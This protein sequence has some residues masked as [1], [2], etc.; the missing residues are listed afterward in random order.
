MGLG[1]ESYSE[2]LL[3]DSRGDGGKGGKG[4]KGAERAERAERGE[5]ERMS[6]QIFGEDGDLR[7]L[8]EDVE[9]LR[10]RVED[11]KN[12]KGENFAAVKCENER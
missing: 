5:R 1:G 2:K 12:R 9:V 3:L 6:T 7:D 11:F 10:N 4:G 8:T